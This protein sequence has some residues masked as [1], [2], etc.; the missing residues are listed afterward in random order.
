MEY[1]EEIMNVIGKPD[2]YE[3]P[4]LRWF[5]DNLTPLMQTPPLGE[6]KVQWYHEA[7]IDGIGEFV[8]VER[9]NGNYWEQHGLDVHMT[10]ED[11]LNLNEEL[12]GQYE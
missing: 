9:W 3:N 8:T 2:V 4:L 7:F 12:G 10:V 1:K 5:N 6:V 11:L